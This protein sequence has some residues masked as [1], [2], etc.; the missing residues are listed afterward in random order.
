MNEIQ[1]SIDFA[2]QCGMPERFSDVGINDFD[3]K[4]QEAVQN[5]F[6]LLMDKQNET[7]FFL[8][9]GTTGIGKSRLAGCIFTFCIHSAKDKRDI[10][11][12]WINLIELNQKIKSTYSKLE[13]FRED[14]WES[15][16]KQI[17]DK[18]IKI[19]RLLVL[20]FGDI[21]TEG[22][23]Y[24]GDKSPHISQLFHSIIDYRWKNRMK[25]IFVT[26]LASKQKLHEQLIKHYDASS[27]GRLLEDCQ[28]IKMG[29]EDRRISKSKQRKIWDI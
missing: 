12:K 23:L 3:I 13:H 14:N 10:W 28:L 11:F 29:G 21:K 1:E 8:I 27:I 4:Q 22:N 7:Y 18:Y 5:T 20:E 9:Y 25:T 17:I 2:I 15:D 19:P 24:G 6:K 26:P 16:E